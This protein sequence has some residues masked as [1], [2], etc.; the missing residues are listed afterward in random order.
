MRNLIL[1]CTVV[2]LGI[3]SFAQDVPQDLKDRLQ[4]IINTER[5]NANL[6][7][8]AVSVVLPDGSTWNGSA[9]IASQKVAIDTSRYFRFASYTKFLTSIIIMQL[10]ESGQL[11][12]DD[13][14]K[15]FIEP[16]PNVDMNLTLR[17]LLQHTATVGD[18]FQ[19]ASGV[20]MQNPDSIFDTRQT[21]IDHIPEPINQK[22]AFSYNNS[23][24][25]LLGLV[26]ESVTGSS[27]AEVFQARLA[28][29][30][31]R[32]DVLLAPVNLPQA[33]YN[34]TWFDG[35]NGLQDVGAAS[36]NAILTANR[37]AGGAV[38]TT[39]GMLSV[40]RAH[41]Q[42]AY[43]DQPTLQLMIEASPKNSDYALGTMI[44]NVAGDI[45]Y[46]HGGATAQ[47]TRTFYD[48]ENRIG[49]C[50]AINQHHDTAA[51][52]LFRDIYSICKAEL[53]T[54][55][56]EP[57]PQVN[58]SFRVSQNYPNPFNPST[59]ID[60]HLPEPG[61]VNITIFDV[62]GRAVRTFETV[63]QRAGDQQI[64]WDGR[65]HKGNQVN[66]G[67]YYCRIQFGSQSETIKML[68]LK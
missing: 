24:H 10:H 21:L 12:I 40:L 6:K 68:M 25:N 14:L 27:G 2:L 22:K 59:S 20:A 45:L 48:P 29:P 44:R 46:G 19:S 51:E 26:I 42:N 47:S 35:G 58:M 41:F 38:G 23:N 60:Y 4:D 16:I 8:V 32:S 50:V 49:V 1:A 7:G 39:M 54:L 66:T 43:L 37:F 65:N 5:V 30:I 3:N 28:A 64:T 63:I 56:R 33:A 34:G 55:D 67:V 61:L 9:G 15:R 31:G 11:S 13:S 53:A 52:D 57:E 18:F 36:S 62:Q 17:E